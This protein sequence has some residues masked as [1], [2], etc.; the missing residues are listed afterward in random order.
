MADELEGKTGKAAGSSEA[1][2]AQPKRLSDFGGIQAKTDILTAEEVEG[3]ELVI[4][5]YVTAKGSFGTY[6]IMQV[7]RANGETAAVSCGGT[8][9]M[10]AL[11]EAK[12][13]NA[14]PIFATLKRR[15]KTWIAV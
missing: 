2:K 1:P 7:D 6:A 13:E 3:E 11:K 9:I 10:K 8:L 5:S 14:F 15:N 12:D 4:K